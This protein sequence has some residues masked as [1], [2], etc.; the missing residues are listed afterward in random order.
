MAT[1]LQT[2]QQDPDLPIALQL[3]KHWH[4]L[5]LWWM[6]WPWKNCLLCHPGYWYKLMSL[7]DIL[8]VVCLGII[9]YFF[10]CGSNWFQL[11]PCIVCVVTIYRGLK[12]ETS[13]W[14]A[15]CCT[16]DVEMSLALC[17]NCELVNSLP[18]PQRHL[19]L[20]EELILKSDPF[21]VMKWFAV[22][23]YSCVLEVCSQSEFLCVC[24]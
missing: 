22:T 11:C 5:V 14:P 24:I 12:Q 23:G 20:K 18:L 1:C 9:C 4:P 3:C 21:R 2:L 19:V 13:L 10:V 16:E 8:P 7:R 17:F 15:L 6:L